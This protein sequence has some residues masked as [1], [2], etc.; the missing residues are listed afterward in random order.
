MRVKESKSKNS[1]SLSI[2][3]STYENGKRSSKIVEKLG[4]LEKIAVE[5]PDIDPRIWADLRAKELTD[6]EQKT[7]RQVLVAYSTGKVIAKGEQRLYEGGYLFLQRIYHDLGLDAMCKDIATRH[8][9][10]YD[11]DS[12]LSRLIY[13]RILDP[14]S[15]LSTHEYSKTLLE[16]QTSDLQHIYR[17]L[18]VIAAENDFIQSELYKRS[19]G[20]SK[21]NDSVLYYDCT[22]FFFEIEQEDGLKQYGASK[23]NRPNPI[24]EMGLFMDGDG[25][26]L[27]FSIHPGNTNEQVT[28]CPLEEKVIK[29]F[30][31]SRFVVCT[32]AGLS[33]AANR[34]FNSVEG[35]SFITTQS[36]KQLKAYLK[37]WAT[38][39]TGWRATTNG[40][41]YN[42]A[43][44]DVTKHF[45]TVFYKERWINDGDLEQRLIVTFSL[46]YQNYQRKIRLRQIERA[47]RLIDLAPKSIGKP[48]QNDFKRL[49][50]TVAH[51]ANGEIADGKAYSLNKEKISEE[52]VYDGFYGVCTNL[53]DSAPIIAEVN[54]RRWEIEECFRIMKHEFK[55]R[56]V[57]LSDD[58]RILAH[59]VTCFI[60]LIVY[61][62][63]ERRL[64]GKYTCPEIINGLKAMKFLK[65]KGEGYV[66][67]YT[68]TDFT[69]DLHTAFGFRTDYQMM[70]TKQ[71]NKIIRSTKR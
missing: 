62:L 47:Q 29:D 65:V 17:S 6:L 41:E 23:E 52:E 33:S 21:R 39:P 3:K 40:R 9:Y 59:F 61:R 57:Y 58:D 32:D 11:L 8:K 60:A 1:T 25:V 19:K 31:H 26:P 50:E 54:S 30:A 53:E 22:N 24:V 4:N 71:M 10:T 49:I 15:K 56:P 38:E 51:T 27:A 13:G 45:N 7:N 36:I 12:V 55:A 66:P 48:R 2:I 63:T 42:I 69:D 46:K 18:D 20:V 44:L 70:T 68:R 43:E 35:R 67:A 37:T 28:L 64:G 34:K 16:P 14:A 5:H